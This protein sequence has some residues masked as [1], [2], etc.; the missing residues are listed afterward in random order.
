MIHFYFNVLPQK[1]PAVFQRK[2]KT[3]AGPIRGP[4]LSGQQVLTGVDNA[5]LTDLEI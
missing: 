3:A 5:L 1:H 4:V 2:Q